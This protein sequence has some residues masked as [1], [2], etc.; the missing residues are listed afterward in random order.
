MRNI[1][2][3]IFILAITSAASA[4][5]AKPPAQIVLNNATPGINIDVFLDAG[6]VQTVKVDPKGTTGFD[7]D[8]LSLGKPQGQVYIETCKDGQRVR[9]ISD[10]T[11]VPDE[12]GCNRKPVGAVFTF[13]CTKKITINFAAAKASFAGCAPIYTNKWVLTAVGGA[14]TSIAIVAGGGSNSPSILPTTAFVNSTGNT[15]SSVVTVVTPAAPVAPPAAAPVT[16]PV[17]TAPVVVT[18]NPTG[19][20]R[21]TG[22][23]VGSDPRS[24]ES[25]VQLCRILQFLV[26]ASGTGFDITAL[27]T[28]FPRFGGPLNT[29]TGAWSL[30][31]TSTISGS[32]PATWT[33]R[34]TFGTTTADMTI[35]MTVTVNGIT[36]SVTYTYTLAKP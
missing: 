34:G 11:T 17:A 21:V 13:T 26:D 33:G 8:F 22:C 2:T 18:I 10:G 30:T 35:V 1:L 32:I 4:Q 5:A 23:T 36:D 24:H 12:D 25:V 7:L 31:A 29:T 19:T 15:S 14:V 3:G 16:P 9:I 28:A 20:W 6:K 27:G